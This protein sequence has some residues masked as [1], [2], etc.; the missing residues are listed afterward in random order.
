MV[1]PIVLSRKRESKLRTPLV[2]TWFYFYGMRWEPGA[3]IR[4]D[5]SAVFFLR[6]SPRRYPA[7][8]IQRRLLPA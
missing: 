6:Q 3:V 7:A 2:P 4:A 5:S 8:A 1:P